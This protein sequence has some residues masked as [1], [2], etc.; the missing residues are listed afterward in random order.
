MWREYKHENSHWPSLIKQLIRPIKPSFTP[1]PVHPITYKHKHK[2]A[3]TFVFICDLCPHSPLLLFH[4]FL[5]WCRRA[6]CARPHKFVCLTPSPLAPNHSNHVPPRACRSN[7]T[8][9]TIVCVMPSLLHPL[10]PS[11]SPTSLALH[12][13]NRVHNLTQPT[14]IPALGMGKAQVYSTRLK[15]RTCMLGTESKAVSPRYSYSTHFHIFV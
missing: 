9:C 4:A 8:I 1:T 5:P 10:S 7:P 6:Q 3:F 13:F 2:C 12:L 14:G 11:E 15:T